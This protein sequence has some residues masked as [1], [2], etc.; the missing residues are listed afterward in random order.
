MA[1]GDLDAP[2]IPLLINGA[3]DP[4]SLNGAPL[5]TYAKYPSPLLG[6]T[7][8][9]SW[10][11]LAEDGTPVDVTN[12]PIDVDPDQ[13]TEYGFL[14]PIANHFVHLLNKGQVFYSYYLER[15]G[16]GG[17]EESKRIHFGVGKQGLLSA[18][19]I[20]E[21]H[22]L[23]LD[24]DAIEGNMTIALAPVGVMNNGDRYRLIWKGER[25]DGSPGPVFNP[26]VKILS[27]TDTDPTNNPRQVLSW[28]IAKSYV[29]A[30]RGGK[31]TLSYEITYASSGALADTL[32]AERTFL[33]T[34]PG[35]A[36]LPVASIKD[37]TGSEINPGQFPQGI[38]VVIPIYRGIRVGDEVLVY[39]T[40]TGA[41]SGPNKNSIQ[42]LK[43]DSS[44][45]ESG[46]VEVPFGQQ[47]LLDNR[48]GAVTILYEY[49][50]PDAAGRGDELQLTIREPLVLPTPSVDRSVVVGGRDE[51]N[52]ILAIDGAYITIPAG[53]TIGD[54]DPVKAMWNGFGGSG[55]YETAVPSQLNPM[56]FKVPADVLPPNFGKTVEVIYQVAGQD[57]EPALRLYVRPLANLPGL[58]CEKVQ[59]GS[60]ATL[61][62]SDVPDAGAILSVD[63]WPFISTRQQVRV[64]LSSSAVGERE[65]LPVRD[66]LPE[67][68]TG[69]VKTRLM[70]THLAGIATNALFTLKASVSFDGANSFFTFS[71]LS[72]KL[73]D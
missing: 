7:L 72:I 52:P 67:E 70:K 30:L 18:P 34:A 21:S 50:R 27:D 41:G 13:E 59:I 71:P 42:Y 1:P 10:L 63:L 31:I 15:A 36:Q 33:V 22:N 20:K 57:A 38:R 6:D 29:V 56:K 5:D 14:M 24:P 58:E 62:L 19:Q 47:W 3:L 8:Y 37:L 61:K 11:G 65:I 55:S 9:Q 64:W 51:L 46:K 43:I 25:A 32:S 69:R 4:D 54:G 73:L 16:G 49:A 45:I 66:V 35:I 39:G 48:G 2:T 12:I 60:P 53:A 23:Q 40:R 68:V 26:P 28:T 44:H 17:R